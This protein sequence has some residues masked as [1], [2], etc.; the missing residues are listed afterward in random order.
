MA[1]EPKFVWRGVM[2]VAPVLV[3]TVLGLY[4]LKQDR[5][6]AEAQARERAQELAESFAS[7]IM[8]VLQKEPS[9]K[10]VLRFQLDSAGKLVFPPPVAAIPIP[11]AASEAVNRYRAG[12]LA[13]QEGRDEEA[14]QAFEAVARDHPEAIGETGL[15]LKPLAQLKWIE[16]ANRVPQLRDRASAM[17]DSLGSNAVFQPG[18]LTPQILQRLSGA[19]WREEWERHEMIRAIYESARSEVRARFPRLLWAGDWLLA[20]QEG[21]G[22]NYICWHANVVEG[23]AGQAPFAFTASIGT[24]AQ[25]WN[26][27]EAEL[28]ANPI[29][30]KLVEFAG[31]LPR[32][33]DYSLEIGGKT[34]AST[35]A[36]QLVVRGGGSKGSGRPWVKSLTGRPPDGAFGA[37]TRAENGAEYLKAAIHLISPEMLYERQR[38]RALVF[39]L[40]IAASAAAAVIGC[41]SALRAF[42]RQHRLAELK[43]DF[44][45]SVSHELRA[46]IASVRLMAEGLE[47][48]SVTE[49][50]KQHEYFRFIVQEC[51]RLGS[52]IENVLDFS[53]IDQDRKEYEFE[54]T[55]LPKLVEQTVKFMEPYAAERQV[56][57]Q[58]QIAGGVGEAQVDGRAIQQA[59]VNLIDNAIK[60]SPQ[61]TQVRIGLDGTDSVRISVQDQGA[62]IP[63]GEREKI[64]E[65]FYRCGSELRRE[66]QG[67]GIGLS[68]VKHIVD[69]HSG[70]IHVSGEPGKGSTFTIVLPRERKEDTN[71]S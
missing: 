14:L 68:I 47:R 63:A 67:V 62:G 45:S 29:N 49:S 61:G 48:G 8:G 16:L 69:A 6:L 11:E 52:M 36:L 25:N 9:G 20:R 26:T 27:H 56:K 1:K 60:H 15:P 3:L 58:T 12:V 53:R 46:P 34:I 39:G 17:E 57:L 59:L 70:T 31:R 33:F 13:M 2:I 35:N 19:R 24:A 4:S 23:R 18:I 64:F 28:L 30:R 50:E 54:P 21:D 5:L 65:R 51:R 55:D 66:T 41:Y 71:E 32:H 43:S 7:E 44:V 42:Q 22:V 40:L 10:E 37:S 38:D